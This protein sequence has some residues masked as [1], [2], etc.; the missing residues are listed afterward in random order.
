MFVF[1]DAGGEGSSGPVLPSFTPAPDI[2]PVA[3]AAAAA[4]SR[5]KTP[6]PYLLSEAELAG[7]DFSSPYF[8][9]RDR[10]IIKKAR[11]E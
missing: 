7:K 8:Y 6:D 11:K 9:P 5:G 10:K 1:Q 3:P 2:L 4:A